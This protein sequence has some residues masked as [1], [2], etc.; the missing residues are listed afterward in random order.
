LD[1]LRSLEHGVELG[2]EQ[3]DLIVGEL[4]ARQPRDVDDFLA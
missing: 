2:A 3:L 1:A 4:Q